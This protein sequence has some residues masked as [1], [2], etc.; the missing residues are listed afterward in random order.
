MD[1][2]ETELV[3]R[4]LIDAMERRCAGFPIRYELETLTV[5]TA[6]IQLDKIQAEL[7]APSEI[8]KEQ[9]VRV[10]VLIPISLKNK[11]SD[12]VI[13]AVT[14]CLDMSIED[15]ISASIPDEQKVDKVYMLPMS[16]VKDLK[17]FSVCRLKAKFIAVAL[18]GFN[19]KET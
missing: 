6:K 13:K 11:T 9:T 15:V 17:R 2:R 4:K 7:N 1:I 18:Q 3:L 12:D 8:N 16:L 19:R 5:E 14:S 10:Q